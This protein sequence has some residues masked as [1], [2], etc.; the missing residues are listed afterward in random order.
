MCLGTK[1]NKITVNGINV[2]TE[3]DNTILKV[4]LPN[5][6]NPNAN[7]NFDIHF[8]TY[9]DQGDVRRRMKVFNSWGYKQWTCGYSCKEKKNTYIPYGGR[10]SM[11]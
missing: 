9:F 4:Y 8:K 6:L 10:K 7:I 2:K 3:L 1:I 5:A 11:F